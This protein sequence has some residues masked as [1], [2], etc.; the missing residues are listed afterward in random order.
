MGERALVICPRADRTCDLYRSQW[1]GGW[2]AV[3][4]V[5]DSQHEPNGHSRPV[6]PLLEYEWRWESTHECREVSSVLDYLTTE[7]VYVIS[8][9]GVDVV[10]PLWFGFPL[11]EGPT[12]PGLG[13]L[14][15]LDSGTELRDLRTGFRHLKTVLQK[16][17]ARGL[18]SPAM[19]LSCLFLALDTHTYAVSPQLEQ[20]AE[21]L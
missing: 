8:A 6:S 7:I 21:N 19:M 2:S 14:V 20:F 4:R 12:A 16:A 3:S 10:L 13:V 9:D 11:I 5:F 1:A 18:L 17:V 15:H